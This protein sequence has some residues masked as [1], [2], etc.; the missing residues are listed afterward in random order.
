MLQLRPRHDPIKGTASP[1]HISRKARQVQ[2]LDNTRQ[3]RR[4]VAIMFLGHIRSHQGPQIFGRTRRLN[5]TDQ[6]K[7]RRLR[8]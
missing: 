1:A 5:Y 7:S 8:T 2:A 4:C 3:G 6:S